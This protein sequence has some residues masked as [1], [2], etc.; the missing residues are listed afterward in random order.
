MC[1]CLF[2]VMKHISTDLCVYE[3]TSNCPPK[4]VILP[5]ALVCDSMQFRVFTKRMLFIGNKPVTCHWFVP[6]TIPIPF[7]MC[8]PS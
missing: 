7:G 2:E 6:V 8:D 4:N 1:V 3:L 5:K